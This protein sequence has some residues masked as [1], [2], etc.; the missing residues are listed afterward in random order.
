MSTPPYSLSQRL[1]VATELSRLAVTSA[2]RN[3]VL[4]CGPSMIGRVRP[5]VRTPERTGQ[6][7]AG[8]VDR[9]STQCRVL[10][11]YPVLQIPQRRPRLDAQLSTSRDRTRWYAARPRPAD[12][13]G[14]TRRSAAATTV[15]ATGTRRPDP[16]TRP[17]APA[18]CPM[19]GRPLP[20]PR[21]PPD[22]AHPVKPVPER[23]TAH[24]IPRTPPHATVRS[25]GAVPRP[26][27]PPGRRQAAD[28]Q[29]PPTRQTVRRPC[30]PATH[31]P[32]SR[33]PGSPP[34]RQRLSAPAHGAAATRTP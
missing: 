28:A 3:D 8:R 15:P 13:P 26:L 32:D 11:Q 18:R 12:P 24:R 27:A 6:V 4:P 33:A 31:R 7:R 10:R 1:I 9:R 20:A 34:H 16:P 19:P 23:R 30:R 22:A 17:P 5:R 14:T 21:R 25:P 29:M 2:S